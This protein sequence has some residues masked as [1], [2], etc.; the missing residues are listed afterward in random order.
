MRTTITV[1]LIIASCVVAVK[2]QGNFLCEPPSLRL[3]LHDP[4]TGNINYDSVMVDTCGGKWRHRQDALYANK[5][6]YVRFVE[7]PFNK[8][9]SFGDTVALDSNF[10]AQYDSTKSL[11]IA[12]SGYSAQSTPISSLQSD[13]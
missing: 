11:F 8:Q 10:A 4:V 5:S 9:Y 12:L 2:M 13:C 3:F 7:Y 1:M 6:I